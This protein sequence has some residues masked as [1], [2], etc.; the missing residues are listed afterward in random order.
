MLKRR[1]CLWH[2]FAALHVLCRPRSSSAKAMADWRK[3]TRNVFT[4]FP[5]ALKRFAILCRPCGLYKVSANLKGGF[6]VRC[7]RGTHIPACNN[8]PTEFPII[9]CL[10][11][12]PSHPAP[13]THLQACKNVITHCPKSTLYERGDTG[14]P[15][16]RHHERGACCINRC[17]S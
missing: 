10:C 15:L 14:C 16:Y 11:S 4:T 1:P 5:P 13:N 6:A 17:T 9:T 7:R 2:L 3:G 12:G 8:A